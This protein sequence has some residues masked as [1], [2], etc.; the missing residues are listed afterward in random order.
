MNN[1]D[2]KIEDVFSEAWQKVLAG[3][4]IEFVLSR[5]PEHAQGLEPMLRLTTAI[6]SL[7]Q[8]A[9]SEHLLD[10]VQ[11]RAQAAAQQ[12]NGGVTH[13]RATGHTRDNLVVLPTRRASWRDRL[14]PSLPSLRLVVAAALILVTTVATVFTLNTLMRQSNA[15][16]PIETYTGIITQMTTSGWMAG[17]T[18]VFIDSTTEIHGKPEVGA[19]MVCIGQHLGNEQMRALEVWIGSAPGAP[20]GVPTHSDDQSL[21]PGGAAFH[22]G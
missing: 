5:Y 7:P 3:D 14:L 2:R 6:R 11:R 8:P 21:A 22:T 20:T 17:D 1:G 18:Q 12:Q 9:L 19:Y 15:R 13:L 4:S 16:E 10:R